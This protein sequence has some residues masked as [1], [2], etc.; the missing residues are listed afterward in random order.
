MSE[1]DGFA[2]GRLAV[3]S[4][5]RIAS[6][7]LCS[8]VVI[9]RASLMGACSSALV[10]GGDD[11]EDRPFTISVKTLT[12]RTITLDVTAGEKARTVPRVTRLVART[13]PNPPVHHGHSS[14]CFDHCATN[15][16]VF[17]PQTLASSLS[18][19]RHLLALTATDH[20]RQAKD[21]RARAALPGRAAARRQPIS[22]RRTAGRPGAPRRLRRHRGPRTRTRHARRRGRRAPPHVWA[23]GPR[24]PVL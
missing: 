11:D 8:S 18:A 14:R 6:R 9:A 7:P 17:I 24:R 23:P 1:V 19:S 12:G 15:I 21:C 10:G 16:P 3:R 20:Q 2:G 22:G 4:K 13:A 5:P